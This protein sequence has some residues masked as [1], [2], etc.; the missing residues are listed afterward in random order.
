[1]N[2]AEYEAYHGMLHV[3]QEELV[4]VLILRD[5]EIAALKKEKDFLKRA[6][7]LAKKG[8][9][10]GVLDAEAEA[11]HKEIGHA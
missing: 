1:M 2:H 7:E 9:A 4:D 8:N 6:L 5:G 3:S 11:Y 10:R